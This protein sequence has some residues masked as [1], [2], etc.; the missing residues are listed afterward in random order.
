MIAQCNENV[1]GASEDAARGAGERRCRGVAR[2]EGG[3]AP[4]PVKPPLSDSWGYVCGRA[5]EEAD[6]EKLMD[7]LRAHEQVCARE[8]ATTSTTAITTIYYLLSTI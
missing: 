3:S 2:A 7:L 8:L 4:G 1:G 5:Q 6:A